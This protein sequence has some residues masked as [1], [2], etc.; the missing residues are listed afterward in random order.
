L[1]RLGHKEAQNRVRPQKAQKHKS[2]ISLA[3][4]SHKE[5]QTKSG[6]KRHKKHKSKISF[7]ASGRKETQNEVRPQK[8]QKAQIENLFWRASVFLFYVLFVP[9]VAGLSSYL[10]VANL[11]VRTFVDV[12]TARC[13]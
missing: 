8:A 7:G 9:F 13:G 2:K 3:R 11:R 6:R 12:D 10:F 1:A 4:L 5:T